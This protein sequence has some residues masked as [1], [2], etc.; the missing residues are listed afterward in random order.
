MGRPD[1]PGPA[2]PRVHLHNLLSVLLQGE[3]ELKRAPQ[4]RLALEVLLL[5]VIHLEPVLPLADWLARLETLEQRLEAGPRVAPSRRAGAAEPP[6]GRGRAAPRPRR[7]PRPPRVPA[8]AGLDGPV[9]GLFAVCPGKGRRPPVRQAGPDAG[10]WGRSDHCLKIGLRRPWNAN[11]A[12]PRSPPA[13]V[14]PDLFRPRDHLEF[15]VEAP[16]TPKKSPAAAKKPL[17]MQK[18]QQQA[19]EIFGGEWLGPTPGKEEPE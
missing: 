6:A 12:R 4:P 16:K 14:G 1:P 17:D 7:R 15:E 13:G 9:A 3:E 2:G 18:L 5:R 10:W 11:G 19:L 8:D